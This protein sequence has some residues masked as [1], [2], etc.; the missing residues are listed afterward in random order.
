MCNLGVYI[1]F[2]FSS[3]VY[4]TF[5]HLSIKEIYC[6]NTLKSDKEL[7]NLAYYAAADNRCGV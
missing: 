1:T 3:G 7:N 5:L 6:V 2:F 4:I